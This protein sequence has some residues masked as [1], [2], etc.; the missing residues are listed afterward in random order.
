MKQTSK[1]SSSAMHTTFNARQHLELCEYNAH[2]V[3]IRNADKETLYTQVYI[4]LRK[5]ASTI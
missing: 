4:L 1:Y 3:D 2:T 5:N